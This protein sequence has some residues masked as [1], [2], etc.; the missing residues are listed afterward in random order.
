MP[1]RSRPTGPPPGLDPALSQTADA[2]ARRLAPGGGSSPGGNRLAALAAQLLQVDTA[3]ISLRAGDGGDGEA[4]HVV[5]TAG[6]TPAEAHTVLC[7]RV[8][9]AEQPLRIDDTGTDPRADVLPAAVKAEVGSYLGVPMRADNRATVGTLC[10]YS[11]EP[12]AWTQDDQRVLEQLASAV[13]TELELAALTRDYD[14]DRARWDDAIAAAGIGNFDWDLATGR[15]QWD[16]PLIQLFG[17]NG[18]EKFDESIEAFNARVHPDDVPD[19]TLKL[20]HAIA[21]LGLYE[22]EYRIVLPGNVVRR[23]QARGRATSVDGTTADRVAGSAWDVSQTRGAEEHAANILQGMPVGYVSLDDDLV[24]TAVNIA[25][26]RLLLTDR[27]T[28]V[29]RPIVEVLPERAAVALAEHC[30]AVSASRYSIE[31]ELYFDAPVAA[32]LE[33]R[34]WPETDGTAIYLTDITERREAEDMAE[35]IAEYDRST[36][37]ALQ[38]ALLTELPQPDDLELTAR[39]RAA[40]TRNKVGGDWYDGVVQSGGSTVVVVGDVTGHDV[41]AAAAMGQLRSMLRVL[42]WQGDDRPETVLD[43]LDRAVAALHRRVLATAVVARVEQSPEQA[44]AGLRTLRWCS[45]GHPMPILVGPDGRTTILDTDGVMLGVRPGMTRQEYT[46][47][48]PPGATLLLYT[49]GLVEERGF[50]VDHGVERLCLA[51]QRHHALG[52]DAFLDAILAEMVADEPEDD[53]VVLALRV[54]PAT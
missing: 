19:V 22:A 20:Q 40:A 6:T 36:A 10:I 51:A 14:F 1:D 34:V 43:T 28:A 4:M 29:G 16:Q 50:T 52:T 35:R 17:Y 30:R 38:D 31:V 12:R 18:D 49:D 3:V 23:V 5:G 48:L 2:T 54:H 32:W 24:V 8:A 15:L 45:A 39:Y 9:R 42:A 7:S 13:S 53:V 25:A 37:I 21:T 44:A 46:A 26:E 11:S 41:S 47:D 33:V 27:L